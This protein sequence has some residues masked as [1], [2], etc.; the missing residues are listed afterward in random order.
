[1]AADDD[2][3]LVWRFASPHPF[4]ARALADL[5]TKATLEFIITSVLLNPKFAMEGVAK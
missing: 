1:M 4:S 2:D 5:R 3:K